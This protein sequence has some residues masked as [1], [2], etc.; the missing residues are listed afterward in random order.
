MKT[1]N[2]FTHPSLSSIISDQAAIYCGT[3][4]KYNNGSIYGRWIDLTL[5]NS[6]DELY[7]I[8]LAI[9]SDENDPE[10]MFQDFQC[11]DDSLI[12]E[13][14]ISDDYFQLRDIINKINEMDTKELIYLNNTYCQEN[15]FSDDEI[16]ENN[17]DFFET[18]FYGKVTEAVRAAIYGQY[19]FSD[20]YVKFNGYGNLESI[21]NFN[22]DNLP[23]SVSTI[24]K[25]IF[26]NPNSFNL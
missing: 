11:I 22:I 23:E 1:S 14:F 8:C 24:A 21:R 17:E 13:S 20:D 3:Y 19:N 2:T 15:N 9:H 18:F 25:Y 7:E 5:V 4:A 10:L 26:E 12:G 16:F 6:K